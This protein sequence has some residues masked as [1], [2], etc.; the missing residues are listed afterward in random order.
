M[1]V[2]TIIVFVIP[3][4]VM[5]LS[6]QNGMLLAICL[7][8]S[9]VILMVFKKGIHA[10][11]WHALMIPFAGA[12]MAFII[13]RSAFKTIRQGGIYWRNTFYSLNELRKQR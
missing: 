3:L 4:P 11:W 2:S 8:V 1:A 5:L 9:Q 13:L 12:I 10:E 7:L 6:G